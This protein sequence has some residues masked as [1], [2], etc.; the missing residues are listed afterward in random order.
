[1]V[2]SEAAIFWQKENRLVSG[3]ALWT[4][5]ALHEKSLAAYA[6]GHHH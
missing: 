6:G 2:P 1:M 5:S 3:A 4:V